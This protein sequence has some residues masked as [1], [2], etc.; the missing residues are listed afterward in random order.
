MCQ[1][2]TQSAPV[3]AASGP[4]RRLPQDATVLFAYGTLRFDAVLQALIGR[5]LQGETTSAPGWRVASLDG[6]VYPGLVA[7]PRLCGTWPAAH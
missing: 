6:R 2:T 7:S 4:Q 5:I 3:L 1:A